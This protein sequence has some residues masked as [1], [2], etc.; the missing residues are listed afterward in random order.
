MGRPM[1]PGEM[2]HHIDG[3]PSN[4]RNDNLVILRGADY[5]GLIHRRTRALKACGNVDWE[6]CYYCKEYD[7]LKNLSG[8]V[9]LHDKCK[10]AYSK[11]AYAKQKRKREI[12]TLVEGLSWQNQIEE[13][14]IEESSTI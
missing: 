8:S 6:K 2:M 3:M 9:L 4:N 12:K 10:K 14:Q 11:E 5:H 7:D 13:S 1:K